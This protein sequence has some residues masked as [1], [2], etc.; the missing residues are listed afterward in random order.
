MVDEDVFL[1]VGQAQ[2]TQM[3][4]QPTHAILRCKKCDYMTADG[5]ESTKYIKEK[6][7]DKMV[8]CTRC[9]GRKI[10][11]VDTTMITQPNVGLS[12]VFYSWQRGQNE[13]AKRST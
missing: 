4:F 12:E 11:I 7:K 6:L 10:E 8:I 9:E 1:S 13:V 5:I 3:T 2:E